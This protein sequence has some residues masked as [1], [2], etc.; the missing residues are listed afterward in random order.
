MATYVEACSDIEGLPQEFMQDRLKQCTDDLNL[1]S[2]YAVGKLF[3]GLKA[4]SSIV[5]ST[6]LP[7]GVYFSKYSGN[8]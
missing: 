6:R 8:L 5:Q 7:I 2:A 4:L 1:N 3:Q